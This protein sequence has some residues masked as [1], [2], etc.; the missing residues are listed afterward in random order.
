FWKTEKAQNLFIKHNV[1]SKREIDA[2]V[3]ILLENY[4][5]KVQIES[6]LMGDLALNHIVPTAI[7][8]QNKLIANTNGLKGLGFDNTSTLR[9]LRN[10]SEYIDI[11]KYSDYDMIEELHRV[12]RIKDTKEKA[13]A[14]CDDIKNKY[15]DKIRNAVDELELYVSD[16]DWP[17]VKYREMLFIKQ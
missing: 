8:Y 13:I 5:K 9:M 1:L 15:F 17:L 16:D 6:R 3:E 7:D 14:Y 10:I 12:N 11:V 2:R 4:I